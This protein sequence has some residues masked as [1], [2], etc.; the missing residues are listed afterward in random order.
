MR[1]IKDG[2]DIPDRLVQAHEDG[3]V[4]FFCGAGIS[5]SAGL[6]GFEGLTL[7]IFEAL[8]ENPSPSERKAFDEKRFDQAIDLFERRIKNRPLVREKIQKVLTPKDLNDPSTTS[9]HSALIALAKS[10]DQTVRLVTTNFDRIFRR[11]APSVHHYVAPLLPIPKKSRWNGLVYLHGLLPENNDAAALNSLVVSSGDFGLAY[12][13]E[14]WAS[15]FVTELFRNYVVCF[16]G[17]S[18]D[19]PVMRYMLDALSADRLQ[20]EESEE[21]YAFGSF[22]ETDGDSANPHY[23]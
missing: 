7:G 9:T 13:A 17:Y 23:S 4:V 11:V 3:E 21:V 2:P 1:F 16:V 5:Y 19:D 10:Q 15:R 12:L 8:G 18:I 20:G 14:R 6:P 22:A